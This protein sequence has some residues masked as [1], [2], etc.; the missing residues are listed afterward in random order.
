MFLCDD[1]FVV[2]SSLGKIYGFCCRRSTVRNWC[3]FLHACGNY[4]TFHHIVINVRVRCGLGWQDMYTCFCVHLCRFVSSLRMSMER[5]TVDSFVTHIDEIGSG[6]SV[7]WMWI[8]IWNHVGA[9]SST[10]HVTKNTF[11]LGTKLPPLAPFLHC[12]KSVK[13]RY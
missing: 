4:S 3:F 8:N 12:S 1:F 11:P 9:F 6:C 7:C 13:M 2:R 10:R 5:A